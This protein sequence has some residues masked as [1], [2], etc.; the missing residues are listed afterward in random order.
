MRDTDAEPILEAIPRS[1]I[2]NRPEITRL[3]T[4]GH[5]LIARGRT[6]GGERQPQDEHPEA[7]HGV[8]P[9]VIDTLDDDD[10]GVLTLTFVVGAANGVPVVVVVVVVVGVPPPP[11]P[12][13]GPLA[14]RF[15]SF[16]QALVTEG[17]P[18]LLHVGHV[19]PETVA[20][21]PSPPQ[22]SR[23]SAPI[24]AKCQSLIRGPPFTS[25][26]AGP[27]T[28]GAAGMAQHDP[29]DP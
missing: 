16:E 21:P 5:R 12:F 19:P 14:S 15:A 2:F 29:L 3:A 26:A 11:P 13:V 28:Q 27:D 1:R 20:F 4:A 18:P 10:G 17:A 6:A 22:P 25:P 23:L 24:S 9:Q 8:V 7:A